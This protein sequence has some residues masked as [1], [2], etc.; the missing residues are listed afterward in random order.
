MAVA[1]EREG[2]GF[3]GAQFTRIAHPANH[4]NESVGESVGSALL[5]IEPPLWGCPASAIQLAQK[6]DKDATSC[7][8]RACE[9]SVTDR[10]AEGHH[11]VLRDRSV[12]L[13]IVPKF[14]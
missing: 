9:V 5:R 2:V 13:P 6:I 1:A 10:E 8:E 3:V 11:R 7:T 4:A 12:R 14:G